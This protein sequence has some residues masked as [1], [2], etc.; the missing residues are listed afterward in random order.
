MVWDLCCG[1]GALG[2]ESLSCGAARCSFVDLSARALKGVLQFLGEREA[3]DRAVT[4]RCDVR[5]APELL[6][7]PVDLVFMDP[8]YRSVALYNWASSYNWEDLLSP[9][10]V[11]FVEGPAKMSLPGWRKRRYGA[12]ALFQREC[13]S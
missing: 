5:R 12:S 4:K 2:I 13:D 1:S 6:E 9:D 8:P 11:V 7:K 3:S 10:G